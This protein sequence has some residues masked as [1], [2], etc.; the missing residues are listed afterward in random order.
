MRQLNLLLAGI[1]VQDARVLAIAWTDIFS[2]FLNKSCFLNVII[3]V[4][5]VQVKSWV[6]YERKSS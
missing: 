4:S 1:I 3:I 2:C 5:S 6:K